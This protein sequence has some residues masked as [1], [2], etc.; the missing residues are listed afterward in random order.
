LLDVKITYFCENYNKKA[1]VSQWLLGGPYFL[2]FLLVGV[3]RVVDLE[4][5]FD[6]DL[7]DVGLDVGLGV[8]F[9]V[10]GRRVGVCRVSGRRD[11]MRNRSSSPRSVKISAC[12]TSLDEVVLRNAMTSTWRPRCLRYSKSGM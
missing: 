9:L 2:E 1:I 6:D 8:G 7:I 5:D 10:V 3:F 12:S 11:L 4:V